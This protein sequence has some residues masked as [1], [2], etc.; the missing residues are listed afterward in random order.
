MKAIVRTLTAG[1]AVGAAYVIFATEAQ[2]TF[3]IA[4]RAI[5]GGI[6]GAFLAGI[7]LAAYRAAKR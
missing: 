2:S 1:A 6:G 3:D 4:V 7:G 5:G